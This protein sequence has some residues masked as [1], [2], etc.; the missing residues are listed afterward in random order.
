MSKHSHIKKHKEEK[1]DHVVAT[2]WLPPFPSV[3][4]NLSDEEKEGSDEMVD[5]FKAY[6]KLENPEWFAK[7]SYSANTVID[8]YMARHFPDQRL[9]KPEYK[10]FLQALAE[11][12]S[13]F[14]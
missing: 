6:L 14:K 2:S 13:N 8:Y 10:E 3:E 12:D 7:I 9:T 11:Q 4:E 5:T 1:K